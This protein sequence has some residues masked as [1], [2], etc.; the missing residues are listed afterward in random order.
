MKQEYKTLQSKGES[1]KPYTNGKMENDI[2]ARLK[3]TFTSYWHYLALQKACQFNIFDVIE[4]EL[5]T[6]DELIKELRLTGI[7]VMVNLIVRSLAV[8]EFE[9]LTQFDQF[10]TGKG[11]VPNQHL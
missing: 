9:V 7:F 6:L 4:S 3:N 11:I 10:Y 5:L 8:L 1:I 2:K